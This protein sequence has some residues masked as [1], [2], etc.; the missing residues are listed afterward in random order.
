MHLGQVIGLFLLAS[1]L[2]LFYWL[3]AEDLVVQELVAVAAELEW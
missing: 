1:L 2:F 3:E